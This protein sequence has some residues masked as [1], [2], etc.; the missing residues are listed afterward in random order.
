M[1]SSLST[2]NEQGI[3]SH[4]NTLTIGQRI[5]LHH[6]VRSTND[7]AKEAG[8]R[9][10]AEGLV[11]LAEEQLAGRGRLGRT[12]IAPVGSSV[13]C[14]VLVRPRFSP[15]HAFY[16]TIATSM[17]IHSVCA[18]MF[19]TESGTAVTIKWPNDVL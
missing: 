19:P 3:Y 5:Q 8:R 11:I 2:Y 7:V 17:S 13:L 1:S 18:N 16:L 15:Q 9:G 10:D 4:L 14:S 12:W 6:Q